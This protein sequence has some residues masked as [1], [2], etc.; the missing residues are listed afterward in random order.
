M[1]I[2]TLT[3]VIILLLAGPL[4]ALPRERALIATTFA[5]VLLTP[6]PEVTPVPVPEPEPQSGFRFFRR[7]RR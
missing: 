5:L 2:I 1:K 3:A 6:E 7:W 4:T